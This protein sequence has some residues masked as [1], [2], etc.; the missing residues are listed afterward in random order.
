M[1][2]RP[3]EDSELLAEQRASNELIKR[4]RKLRWIGMEDEARKVQ[5]SLRS[6]PSRDPVLAGPRDT[7]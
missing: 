3:Q 5:S 2:P 6:I 4:I 1:F 7:D